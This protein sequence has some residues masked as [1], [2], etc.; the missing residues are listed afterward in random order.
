[1]LHSIARIQAIV[2]K[3]TLESFGR[4]EDAIDIVTHHFEI[5]G[6]AS[7]HIPQ[8]VTERHPQIPWREMQAT[9]NRVTHG[10]FSLNPTTLWLSAQNELPAVQLSLEQLKAVETES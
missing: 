1:M 8:G 10:Y 9:R 3:H 5:L 6:E 2:A 4:D 7:R